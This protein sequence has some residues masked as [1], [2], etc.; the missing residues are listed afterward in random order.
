MNQMKGYAMERKVAEWKMNAWTS[1]LCETVQGLQDMEGDRCVV[2]CQWA[3]FLTERRGKGRGRKGK[4]LVE[5]RI[6]H[7]QTFWR[8]APYK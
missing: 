3:H 8:G 7:T 5:G 2:L 4:G 6:C 1:E